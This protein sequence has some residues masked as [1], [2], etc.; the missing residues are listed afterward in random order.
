MLKVTPSRTHNHLIKQLPTATVFI[1]QNF[2]VVH[3]S[4]KWVSYFKLDALS[5]YGK[6]IH[7]IVPRLSH[8]WES[9]LQNCLSGESDESIVHVNQDSGSEITWF[10]T[11]YVP[12]YDEKQQIVGLILQA[13]DITEKKR[14]EEQY[15]KLES[16]IRATS[17]IGKIGC[18]EYHFE[19][20]ELTWCEM[21][22]KIHEVSEAFVPNIDDAV[23]FY[24]DGHSKNTISMVIHEAMTKGSPW[25]ERL[26][27]I[28]AKG[29]EIWVQASGRPIYK[30]DKLIGLT[31]TFQNI[32][33]EVRS[34]TQTKESETRL[35][36]L[37]D[38]LPLNVFIKDTE[39]RKVLV[40][41]A[42]C[43]YL[44]VD[45]PQALLG[46]TDFELYDHE[47]AQV[48]RNEDIKVMETLTPLLSRETT[49]RKKNGE[50][51]TFLT[52]KIPL[53]GTN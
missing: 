36:T 21:T 41:K 12:W 26:Q 24:K 29:N 3:A 33:D 15:A 1:N 52:S 20:N 44:G 48:S 8:K 27:I 22:R 46:K 30:Q 35:R 53:L 11:T 13:E 19:E 32:D 17:E 28:T 25:S 9:V 7:E 14:L 16:L 50:T 6:P 18:W 45:N 39:S 40:N 37:I 34:E 43:A 4:D 47:V 31:G 51:T 49:N 23:Q 42:E 10:E 2:E 38:N 5:I